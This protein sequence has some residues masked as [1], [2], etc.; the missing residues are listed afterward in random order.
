MLGLAAASAFGLVG[1]G[2]DETTCGT[3]T[4]L[5]DGMCVPSSTTTCGTGTVLTAGQCVPD[6][7]VICEQGT[8]YDMASGQCVVDPS[9]CA[10]GT[11]LVGGVCVP[12]DDTLTADLEEATEPNDTTG[13]G[14]FDV[15]ALNA[16]TTIHGCITPRA[17]VGDED[18]WLVTAA[19]PTLLEIT[20]DGVGG[21]AAG[22]LVVDNGIATLPNYA[23][24]GINLVGDTSKRQVYLPVAGDYVLI[25][26][27]SRALLTGEAAGNADTCYYATIKTIAMPAAT[28]AT[29]PQTAGT[30]AGNVRVLSY[31]ADAIG[32]I[33]DITQNTAS[34]SLRTAFIVRK[35]GTFYGSAAFNTTTEDPAFFTIGGLATTDMVEI[36][37]DEVY[38]FALTPQ[39]YTLD[40]FDIA[41]QPLPTAGTVLTV[42]K[43]NGT[44]AAA[45][46]WESNY[47]YFDV[48]AAGQVVH[49]NL[50]SS[51][52][53][54][55]RIVRADVFNTAGASLTLASIS[56]GSGALTFQNQ[57]VRFLQPGRYYM[58]T[59]DPTG[60]AAATYTITST[61]IANTPATL[62][63]GTPATAQALPAQGSGFHTIDL[64]ATTWI[65]LAVPAAANWGTATNARVSIYDL[66]GEGWMG[67]G[68]GTTYLPVQ[69]GTQ[70]PT[71][72][73]PFGRITA[74]DARDFLVRVE[75]TG[76]PGTGPTYDLLIGD[77]AHVALGMSVPGTA[78]LR[79]NVD[80]AAA[81]GTIRYL[82]TGTAANFMQ[83]VATPSQA[84]VDI[85]V[86]RRNADE[87]AA[88]T[89]NAGG[90]GVA[91]TL[92]ATF[93]ATPTW[94]AFTVGNLNTTTASNVDLAVNSFVPRMYTVATGALTYADACAGGTTVMTAQD[95]TLSATLAL[96]A[97]FAA[98]P[99]LGAPV[100]NQVK[101]SSNGFITF[102]TAHTSSSAGN[103]AIPTAA[104]P[105]G[106]IAGYW[107]DLTNITL[108]RKDDAGTNTVTF[109]WV[110]R[111]YDRPAETAQFQV[112]LHTN[113]V[114]DIIYGTTHLLNGSQI[115]DFG[116]NGATVGV[117]NLGG[118]F[119]QQLLFNTNGIL[120][121]TS[122]TLTPQ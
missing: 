23:R 29:L 33:F 84:A 95:D 100:G 55:M 92:G 111:I 113:G 57:Y 102:D 41:A 75:N 96:P 73:T 32:D 82:V 39:A 122:R 14:Q 67:P 50:T 52:N 114:I 16:D 68:T 70:P 34:T 42:S 66:A 37:V 69:T 54:R 77:R 121:S 115:P 40:F 74:G 5:Q 31:Q 117:E 21:L 6:G 64:N 44:I 91:E 109:Q 7:T 112:V 28:A 11:V 2:G 99:L 83:A 90:N 79:T 106:L 76:T 78:I 9:A 80:N 85:N 12:D 108:C 47:L 81:S 58:V 65:E 45:P 24:F 1:C 15:P 120:P 89:I 62:T 86:I 97:S 36:V 19:A 22:F 53:V 48:A 94:V 8:V 118:T 27:D 4:V 56:T 93:A 51:V 72:A 49:F 87:S 20:A 107:D 38:N 59:L 103:V 119:G 98:F 35:N 110:G 26:D 13:A 3:G 17:G 60:V 88:T 18:A 116:S 101:V 105:G 43:K 30:D 25:M 71:G 61:L 10:D 104:A 46:W 63:Y